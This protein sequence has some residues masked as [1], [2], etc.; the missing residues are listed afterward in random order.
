[1]KCLLLVA[2]ALLSPSG[3]VAQDDPATDHADQAPPSLFPDGYLDHDRL[4]STLRGI[5][6]KNPKTVRL[7]SLG[8]SQ[9]G[10][11]L[12][13]ITLGDAVPDSRSSRPAILIVA[14]LEADHVV[15]S[16][17]ALDL[18]ERLAGSRGD[19]DGPGEILD[20]A[21]IYVV[22]RLNPDGAER[23][24]RGEVRS[25][26]RTNSRPIDRDRD[27]RRGEDGP[28]DLDGDGLA[29]RMRIEDAKA[30]LVPDDKDPRILRKADPAKGER[31]RY[32][33]YREG[34]DDDGDGRIDEDPPG[35][36]NLNRN[37]PHRWSEFDPEAGWSPGAEPETQ[38]LIEFIVDHPEIAAIWT[39]ALNDNLSAE[40]KK[41]ASTLDDADL[42]YFAELSRRF[43][44]ARDG[45]KKGESDETK[46]AKEESSDKDT[47]DAKSPKPDAEANAPRPA[48]DKPARSG[49]PHRK[50]APDARASTAFLGLDGTTDGA[51]SEWAYHQLGVVGLSSRLW[52]TP[53]LPKPAEGE[54]KPPA[55]GEGRWLYWN[56]RVLDGRGFVPFRP[57]D[58]PRLGA[59]EIGGW[60]PG[61]R[62]NPPAEQV[63]PISEVHLAFLED[64]AERLP[65]LE[66]AD[67]RVEAKGGGL[68]EVSAS[69]VN[70]GYLPTALNQGVKTREAGPVV[71]RLDLGEAK[72]LA[73]KP[74]HKL[75]RLEGS[76]GRQEFRWLIAAP[77]AGKTIT[78][79]AG[80]ARAG[81][82]RRT[83]ELK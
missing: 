67:V 10:R 44:A 72:L 61:V 83:I 24:L 70:S 12:W 59:V 79:D 31:P 27:G 34:I 17:V 14:N 78:I 54:P 21:T 50:T 52:S 46:P 45:S 4:T 42:P 35:G 29:L 8:K 38:A 5:A 41:P 7:K 16:Q 28:N 13:M 58:H 25:D 18:V 69:V 64:L 1:M 75:N 76:G 51:L 47:K 57:F 77:D 63:E 22:P 36:V 65:S 39:F 3:A 80:A 62:L 37:W 73:G 60:K 55:E 56:D 43:R 53:E 81:R 48:E 20:R 49:E 26:V 74:L 66:L 33:E 32:S 82:V 19:E 30:S 71:V 40:P 23:I 11:D 9:E 2:A 68:F 6:E 15:G